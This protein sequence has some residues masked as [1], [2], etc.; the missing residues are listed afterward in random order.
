MWENILSSWTFDL[1]FVF[2]VICIVTVIFYFYQYVGHHQ[3]RTI[4]NTLMPIL[5]SASL[6][7]ND[8]LLQ[9]DMLPMNQE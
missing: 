6:K 5:L 4:Q 9:M 3:Q 8:F 2:A 1:H 7:E